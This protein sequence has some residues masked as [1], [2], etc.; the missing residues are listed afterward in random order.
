MLP[1]R[2]MQRGREEQGE[3]RPVG[4]VGAQ[5]PMGRE[6]ECAIARAGSE[7]PRQAPSRLL[8]VVPGWWPGHCHLQAMLLT[9]AG[10]W[11]GQQ[12]SET[13]ISG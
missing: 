7:H 12:A 6:R 5:D 3:A 10:A 4:Q 2:R 1:S 8:E 13:S 11:C 9:H